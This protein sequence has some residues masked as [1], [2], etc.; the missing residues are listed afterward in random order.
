[1][2][3]AIEPEEAKGDLDW[4]LD[5]RTKRRAR[6][7]PLALLVLVAFVVLSYMMTTH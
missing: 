5:V 6:M 1:V 3:G 7:A 2:E 4:L